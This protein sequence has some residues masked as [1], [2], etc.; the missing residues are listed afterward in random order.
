M[1]DI[2]RDLE[3]LG[4]Q[5]WPYPE[6]ELRRVRSHGRERGRSRALRFGRPLGALLGTAL[7]IVVIGGVSAAGI[8]ALQHHLSSTST[9]SG[10]T[11][12]AADVTP[13]AHRGQTGARRTSV[14]TGAARSAGIA[15]GQQLTTTPQPSPQPPS[16]GALTVTAN[17]HGTFEVKVGTTINVDLAGTSGSNWSMPTSAPIQIVRFERG[18]RSEG[19]GVS[20]AFVAAAVGQATI[21]ASESPHCPPVC[22]PPSY[23]WQIHIIVVG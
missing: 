22:G 7:A 9:G 15:P 11:A 8:M 6:R 18:S 10:G 16:G 3:E 1:S 14:S 20:A 4:R 17:S 21:Q 19:A 5:V 13:A 23:V 2:E 12:P